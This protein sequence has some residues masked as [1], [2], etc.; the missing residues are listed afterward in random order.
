[1]LTPQDGQ[2]IGHNEKL[3]IEYLAED[4]FSGLAADKNEIYFDNEKI[5]SQEIDLFDKGLGEHTI[6]VIVKDN[7]GN[8]AQKE[9]KFSVVTSIAGAIAD[10]NRLYLEKLINQKAKDVLINDSGDVQKYLDKN[11]KKE[12]KRQEVKKEIM[13]KCIAKKGQ[14]WCEEKL[15]DVFIKIDYRLSQVQQKIVRV[16]Y[17]LILKKLDLYEKLDWIAKVGSGIIKEDVKYLI[18]M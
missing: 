15:G 18:K 2:E 11:A 6:K 4:N 7:A 12:E 8:Q 14:V 16:K 1:M 9:I 17:E 5:A 3:N 13:D 10:V